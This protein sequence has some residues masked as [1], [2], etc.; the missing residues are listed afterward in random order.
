MLDVADLIPDRGGDPNKVRESQKKRFAD[1]KLIDEVIAHY[2]DARATRYAATQIGS[3]IN[4]I[5]KEIGMKKK[6]KEDASD[7]LAQK[8]KL[9]AEKQ[10]TVEAAEAKEKLRDTTMKRIANYVHE[11]VPVSDDEVGEHPSLF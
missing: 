7:L 6:N 8:A 5:Q 10:A 3:K 11:S 1:E 9:E 2:E 4:A